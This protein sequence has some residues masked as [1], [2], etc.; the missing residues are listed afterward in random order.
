MSGRGCLTEEEEIRIAALNQEH[1]V[2]LAA[3]RT[4]AEEEEGEQQRISLKRSDC[5]LSDVSVFST[6]ASTITKTLK[7]HEEALSAKASASQKKE[8]A[9]KDDGAT[10]SIQRS[11]AISHDVQDLVKVIRGLSAASTIGGLAPPASLRIVH[12]SDTHNQ[13]LRG[14]GRAFLPEGDI[15]VH[16][17]NFSIFGTEAEFQQFDEWLESVQDLYRFRVVVPGAKDVKVAGADWAK[18]KRQLPHATHVLCH[19]QAEILGVKFYGVPWHWGFQSNGTLR[20]GAPSSTSFRADEIPSNIHVLVTHAAAYGRL[21]C[22]SIP[23]FSTGRENRREHWGI[24]AI[25]DAIARTMPLV[26]LHGHVHEQRGFVLQLGNFPLSVNSCQSTHDKVN[27]VLYATPHVI[28]ALRQSNSGKLEGG[29]GAG[30]GGGGGG[31]AAERL[32]WQFS[33]DSLC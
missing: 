2:K 3:R 1:R 6:N 15:L 4:M 33:L 18:I 8:E 24:R 11:D 9:E 21:D 32:L 10:I 27:S 12:S 13:L 17:G 14:K 29:G 31:E 19:E 26:H 30:G 25:S 22:I 7:G 23:D 5:R 16:S 20:S 28:K